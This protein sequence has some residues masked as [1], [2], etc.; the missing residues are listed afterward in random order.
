[1]QVFP[2]P[3]SGEA[4]LLERTWGRRMRAGQHYPL[5][6]APSGLSFWFKHWEG[7]SVRGGVELFSLTPESA[8]E[9]SHCLQ[10]VI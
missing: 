4:G 10:R 6:H 5:T 8:S 2:R 7:G 9:E 3:A 1:M